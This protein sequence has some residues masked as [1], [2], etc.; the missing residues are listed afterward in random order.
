MGRGTLGVPGLVWEPFV[1]SETGRGTLGEVRDGLGDPRGGPGRVRGPSER[2][3]TVRGTLVE[4]QDVSG[5]LTRSHR[6]GSVDT[7]EIRD[8]SGDSRRLLDESGNPRRGPGGVEG[9]SW[10]QRRS[11]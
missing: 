1:R 6:D 5:D 9:P 7:Q 8:G 2:F 4:V 3:G 11:P 10:D